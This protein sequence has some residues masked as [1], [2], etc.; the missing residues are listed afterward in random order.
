M[1]LRQLAEAV[2]ELLAQQ[3]EVG[4]VDG[5]RDPPVDVD[6]RLLVGDVVGGHVGVDVDVHAAPARPSRRAPSPAAFSA[7]AT[8][9]SSI[10]M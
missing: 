2:L 5:A 4:D 7:A 3:L 9:S 10:C 1:R 6:L 8:A